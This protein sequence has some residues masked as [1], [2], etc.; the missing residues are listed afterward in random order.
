VVTGGGSGM[1]SRRELWE[2]TFAIDWWGVYY[3][4]RV[5]LP[6]LIASGDGVLVEA[7]AKLAG[8]GL[9]AQ[10][11]SA[12]ELRQVLVRAAYDYAELFSALAQNRRPE[13]HR[14]QPEAMIV[15]TMRPIPGSSATVCP[16][17][18]EAASSGAMCLPGRPITM[19]S[20]PSQS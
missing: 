8:A 19:A 5:F 9:L 1:G 12:E 3:C 15:C 16:A 7:R 14:R 6:L 4:A 13:R 2:R 20:S 11:A 18:C 17:T 10:G